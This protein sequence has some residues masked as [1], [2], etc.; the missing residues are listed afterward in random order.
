[1]EILVVLF[2]FIVFPGFLFT[3][4]AGLVFSW[5]ERKVT[6]RLQWRKGPPLLQ[7]FYDIVKLLGKDI[8][9][10]ASGNPVLFVA[11]PLFGL[12]AAALGSTILLL[13]NLFDMGFTGD[14]IVIAYLFLIPSLSIMLGGLASGN[15]L[16]VTGARR[17]MKLILGYELPFIIVFITAVI[18]N[19]LDLSIVSFKSTFALS[20]ISGAISIL[21]AL[22]CI[23]AKL[24]FPPFDVAEAET[25]IC[26]GPYIE[27]SGALFG[28][29][30][31]T[32]AMA[33]FALP[34][35]LITLFLGGL[36]FI[37]IDILW[38][39]L[40]YFIILLL[41][42]VIKNTNPRVRIDQSIKFFW[43]GL[44]PLGIICLVL[45]IIGKIF[46]IAWL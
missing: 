39:V 9:I 7:P 17:E 46:D 30:K 24:G 18:K 38:S 37:G 3:S 15:P 44:A 19:N 33:L 42:I 25:E 28:V 36:N 40:K 1:M 16:A 43:G 2:Y 35:F 41:I 11:A 13:G 23:Q 20:S 4:T 8:T 34:L 31:I 45:A 5:V 29:F 21:I 22:L 27:Y 6:A 26:E 14:V 32:Q 10:P 12:A